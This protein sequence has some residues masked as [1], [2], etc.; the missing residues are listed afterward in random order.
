MA[1]AGILGRFAADSP[2][3]SEA[4]S[5]VTSTSCSSALS[6]SAS[7]AESEVEGT[8]CDCGTATRAAAAA[9]AEAVGMEILEAASSRAA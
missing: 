4:A 2:L 6:D 9:L 1:A 7:R 8:E 3:A 5:L